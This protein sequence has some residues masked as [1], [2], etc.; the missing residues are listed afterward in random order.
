M[1]DTLLAV[2]NR[3]QTLLRSTNPGNPQVDAVEIDDEVNRVLQELAVDGLVGKTWTDSFVMLAANDY[4]YTLP[5]TSSSEYGAI[6]AVRR[7]SDG[8][9][10]VKRTP[11]VLE[12]M[13]DRQ[14]QGRGKPDDYSLSEQTDQSVVLKVGPIPDGS[15]ESLDVMF[16]KLPGR[17]SS[18]SDTIGLTRAGLAA[19]ELLVAGYIAENPEKGL[20]GGAHLI[21]RGTDMKW[22]ALSVTAGHVVTGE[23]GLYES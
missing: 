18:N 15:T 11:E 6:L 14:S 4:D 13:Y 16:E 9:P 2:R 20:K 7:H 19:L 5:T 10:L 3:I 8:R 12:A 21:R 22:K 17:V 1:S 23:I